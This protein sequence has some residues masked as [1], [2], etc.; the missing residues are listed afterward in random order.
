MYFCEAH[1]VRHSRSLA[2]YPP[3]QPQLPST[4]GQPPPLPQSLP[5]GPGPAVQPPPPGPLRSCSRSRSRRAY[6]AGGRP[7]PRCLALTPALR[8]GR[9]PRPGPARRRT[10]RYSSARHDAARRGTERAVS[11]RP[12]GRVAAVV[13]GRRWEMERAG[14]A[15]EALVWDND[16]SAHAQIVAKAK[17]EFLFGLEE[18]KPSEVG[19]GHGSSTL[20][21][22][23]IINEFPEYGTVEP[24]GEAL[25][26][27]LLRQAEPV[28]CSPER[29]DCHHQVPGWPVPQH[30]DN[31]R[32]DTEAAQLHTTEEGLQAVDNLLEIMKISP[33]L[34]A[35][36]VQENANTSFDPE[37]QMEKNITGSQNVQAAREPVP[38]SQEKP[39]DMFVPSERTAEEKM[40]LIVEKDL[41]ATWTG[42]KQSESLQAISNETEEVHAVQKASC[43]RSSVTNLE[44][45]SEVEGLERFEE[46]SANSQ[47]K[48]QMDS[49]RSLSKEAVVSKHVE[50]QG[51][52]ILWLQKAEEQR[53]RKHSL[54]ETVSVERKMFPK[55]SSHPVPPVVSLGLISSPDSGWNEVC[56]DPRPGSIASGVTPLALHDES[57]EDEVFVKDKN[58]HSKEEMDV[59]AGGQG[60]LMEEEGAATGGYEDV[61]VQRHSDISTDM[62]SSQFENIL[63]NASLYY[64]VESLETLYS[65]P[66]S[67]FSFEMPLTPMIQQRMKE[68]GQFLDRTSASGQPDV[69]QLP[70]GGGVKSCG[71]GIANGLKDVS[72]TLFRG[73]VAEVP[74]LESFILEEP[75]SWMLLASNAEMQ[76]MVLDSSAAMGSNELQEKD[77]TRALGHNLSNGSSSN[78]EAARRLAKRLYHLD[79]FKRSDVAKHLGKN[80]EFSKLVAEEYLKFFDFTGMTLDYS[81]RSFFKAFSLIGETQERER[82]L[83]HFSSRYYQCNPNAISSQ[84][85]VHCLTCAMMLLNTD[86]HGHNIGKKMTYQEFVANLQGMNDGKDFPKGLLKGLYNSIKNEKLEWAVD[87]EEKKKSPS[88]GTDEKDNGNQ[89]KAVSRIG[90]SN[91]PFVDIPHDPN[92]A[93]Y[94]TG[95][96]AR[97][98][99]A[100]MDGK[101]T[102]RGKRGWKT[103]YAVLKGTVLYLQKDEYKPE[104]ALSEED[105]KNAVSVH[106]AL[107]SKAT[108]YEKKP[109][110]LKL[111]TADW[112]VLLFQAQSQEEMHTWINKINCVA[113]VFSAPP[114]PAAIGSQKK[115]SRPLLPATTTKLSQDEQLKSHEAKLKQIS[116]E[117]AEHRSYPPDRKL[118]GK[119]VDDYKLK[120]HY[121]EFEKNRYEIY[122]GLLKEGVKELLSGGENEAP[123]LKKSHSSPSLNQES[124]VSAK[125]KRNVSERKDHRPETPSIK[126]KVT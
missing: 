73:D 4:P 53:R 52:E 10:A 88:D 50:F 64:S 32:P 99:H 107:A 117:L 56:E 31:L 71:E 6:R 43:H 48:M 41:P 80:N 36:K 69:L 13:R 102:P 1:A 118:K 79:R 116:T 60:R 122:I 34:E 106:H 90:N 101:K 27:V 110:V 45:A 8:A 11:A 93:V 66:D 12:R 59:L 42:E 85:G 39:S 104:K 100:D 47:G 87:E 109:N 119:E 94:K 111:K 49:E 112:R 3:P 25:Q 75:W 72:E 55:T 40:Q 23:T 33:C 96:L 115:F 91:N 68:G 57:E 9:A 86:L 84:D 54:L 81:L 16:V 35:T 103:F 62:Y 76:N 74:H 2:F 61:L 18:E 114:F 30:T 26:A 125:V 105:L 124:P 17:Y 22:H 44:A 15:A 65:E 21:P 38:T 97:K 37:T 14:G 82:V 29:R 123:G 20:L 58:N 51:V 70:P 78:L 89:M 83:V 108:D 121:L 120:D 24:S 113:A 126:Q 63:D 46:F 92:A 28:A 7:P 5:A 98:S 95:F 77:A 19:S 67:Y